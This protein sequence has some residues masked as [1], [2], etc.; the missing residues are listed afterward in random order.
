MTLG[1]GVGGRCNKVSRDF[2]PLRT[3]IYTPFGASVRQQDQ[4]VK[5][6]FLLFYQ[7]SRPKSVKKHL[8]IKCEMSHGGWG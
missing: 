5:D 6:T 3:L 2:F 7:S 4:A 1:L 8:F